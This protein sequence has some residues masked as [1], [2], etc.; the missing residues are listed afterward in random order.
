MTEIEMLEHLLSNLRQGKPLSTGLMYRNKPSVS[1]RV[2]HIYWDS[3]EYY[4]LAPIIHTINGFTVP[5]H[6]IWPLD[7]GTIYYIP[8]LDH[9]LFYHS[10]P[11][12]CWSS[13]YTNLERGL[14]FHT[15]EDAISNAKA[16]LGIDPNKE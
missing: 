5:G 12:G 2:R 4:S 1:I 14:V 11:W 8:D 16:M 7:E 13:D 15:E 3:L 6:A 9:P 10:V